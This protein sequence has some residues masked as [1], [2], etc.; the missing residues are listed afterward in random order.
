[1]AIPK[2]RCH[3]TVDP[4]HPH[5]GAQCDR[6]GFRYQRVDGGHD[7]LDWQYE[8][9]GSGLQNLRIL[10]CKTCND[11][12]QPQLLAPRIPADPIP[13]YNPRPE[14]YATES[15]GPPGPANPQ[16]NPFTQQVPG[17]P[18]PQP[19]PPSEDNPETEGVL[20]P[21]EFE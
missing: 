10:V 3:V 17:F 8:Y 14:P 5:S 21:M 20:A 4:G 1:M 16:I 12:P 13:I 15:G 11:N 6:C 7:A 19:P 2:A 9:Q 18:G